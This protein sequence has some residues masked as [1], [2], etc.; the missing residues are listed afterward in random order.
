MHKSTSGSWSTGINYF[1]QNSM[2]DCKFWFTVYIYDFENIQNIWCVNK[3]FLFC[4]AYMN[5]KELKEVLNLDGSTHLN[6]FFANSSD[7]D[8]AGV[9]TWPW[10]KEALTHLGK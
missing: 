7:E 8:V 10:D 6:I 4:R 2:F 3:S 1:V 9:G 5:V